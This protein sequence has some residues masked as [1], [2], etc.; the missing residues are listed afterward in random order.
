MSRSVFFGILTASTVLLCRVVA[1]DYQSIQWIGGEF[2]FPNASI[3][4]SY[5]TCGKYV[6]KNII[7]TRMQIHDN[8]AFL[9]LPR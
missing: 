8:Q 2:E 5:K 7:A 6:V 9:A 3:E 1:A 4:Q